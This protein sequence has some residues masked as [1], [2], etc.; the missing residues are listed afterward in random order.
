MTQPD[1]GGNQK[2]EGAVPPSGARPGMAARL[3]ASAYRVELLL[4]GL[5]FLALA[6]FSSQRFLRQ[7]EAPHF[8]YQAK[9]W[10]DGRLDLDPRTLPNLEDWACV[11]EV[12]GQKVRCEGPLRPTDRWYVSFPAFPSVVMLPLVAVN[13]YQLND[14]SLTVAAGALALVAFYSLL[15]MLSKLGESSREA[16]ENL[17]LTAVLGF[18]TVFFYCAI[19]GEVWVTAEVMGVAF[20]CW[21]VRNAMGARHPLLAG[22]FYAMAVLTRTPLLFTGIFFAME[23]LCP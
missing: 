8:V 14:T 12:D 9:A 10:L 6:S 15:R 7:S 23:A 22:L 5:T 16:W 11:R 2:L 18:G 21:Y 3:W 17:A 1:S 4:F 13:G 20:T 19:R